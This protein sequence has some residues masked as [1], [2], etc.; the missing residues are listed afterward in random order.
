[1]FFYKE[2]TRVF[3]KIKRSY[4]IFQDPLLEDQGKKLRLHDP[5]AGGPLKN[6]PVLKRDLH[7]VFF[8]AIFLVGQKNLGDSEKIVA[9][10]DV[11]G[12]W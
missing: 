12:T 10:L 8:L 6:D 2:S 7:D 1:L 3:A 9:N 5:F 11:P 4:H